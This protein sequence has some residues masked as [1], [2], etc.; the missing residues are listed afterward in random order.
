MSGALLLEHTGR[1]PD[2]ELDSGAA[3]TE[4]GSCSCP[5]N[6]ELRE[7]PA[8][9]EAP[10]CPTAAPPWDPVRVATGSTWSRII[11]GGQHSRRSLVAASEPNR[12]VH[13]AILQSTRTTEE[14]T[15]NSSITR[16]LLLLVPLMILLVFLMWLS[17]RVF[18]DRQRHW[19]IV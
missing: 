10:S 3:W 4:M 2:R 7:S 17:D 8:S 1:S 14:Q 11:S 13:V 19:A 6:I 5:T 18:V 16:L 15:L 12:H 9:R